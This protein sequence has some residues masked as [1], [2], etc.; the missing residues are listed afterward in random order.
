MIGSKPKK[1][2]IQLFSIPLIGILI[3]VQYP[4]GFSC[5]LQSNG[6]EISKEEN[7]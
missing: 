5:I 4:C 6:K 1:F 3:L 7:K 2:Q